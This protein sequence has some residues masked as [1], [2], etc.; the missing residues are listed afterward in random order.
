MD[1]MTAK[2]LFEVGA[3]LVLEGV[4]VGTEI[5]VDMHSWQTAHNFRGVKMIP[6]G[7]HF[8]YFR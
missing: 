3:M 5:G 4:P 2:H 6:P 7:M 8:I 1:Q